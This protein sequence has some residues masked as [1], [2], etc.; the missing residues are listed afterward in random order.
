MR[1]S[2]CPSSA[3][4]RVDW[5]SIANMNLGGLEDA[6]ITGG[7]FGLPPTA[8]PAPLSAVSLTLP[9]FEVLHGQPLPWPCHLHAIPLT[10]TA[11]AAS[12]AFDV[13]AR[14]AIAL[15]A[16]SAPAAAVLAAPSRQMLPS[17]MY[18][19]RINS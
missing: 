15:A 16:P 6:S 11:L 18:S 3:G 13:A 7:T 5:L 19:A 17:R 8:A 2:S 9:A 10:A 12:S 14:P 4:G 1:L